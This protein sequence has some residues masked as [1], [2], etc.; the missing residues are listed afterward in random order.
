MDYTGLGTLVGDLLSSAN[1]CPDPLTAKVV[2]N[3]PKGAVIYG[4]LAQT[5]QRPEGTRA[6]AIQDSSLTRTDQLRSNASEA[7]SRCCGSQHTAPKPIE[8]VWLN[9]AFGAHSAGR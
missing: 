7:S 8:N 5:L 3:P 4:L 1:C 2:G 9:L 6:V